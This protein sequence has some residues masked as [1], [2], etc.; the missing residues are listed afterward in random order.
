MLEHE[1]MLELIFFSKV[2]QAMY[3]IISITF[4]LICLFNCIF[5]D[6][7]VFMLAAVTFCV[8]LVTGMDY[9]IQQKPSLLIIKDFNRASHFL[10]P[11]CFI[12]FALDIDQDDKK[13]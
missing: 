3:I 10:L 1:I 11:E 5:E 13:S 2:V 8:T 4:F 6:D 9:I 7:F 12:I